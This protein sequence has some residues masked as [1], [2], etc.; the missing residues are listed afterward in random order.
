MEDCLIAARL[1]GVSQLRYEC[2]GYGTATF[3]LK[4]EKAAGILFVSQKKVACRLGG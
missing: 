2:P 3:E 1:A 4:S